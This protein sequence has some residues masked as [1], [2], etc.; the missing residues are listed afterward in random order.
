MARRDGIA[1]V[2]GI[3]LLGGL[4]FAVGALVGTLVSIR[5]YQVPMTH[6]DKCQG[7]GVVPSP[8]IVKADGTA[9]G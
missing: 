7:R 2:L 6:C 3:V 5:G 8:G 9:A 4:C 1:P